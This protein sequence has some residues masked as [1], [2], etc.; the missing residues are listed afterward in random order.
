MLA[1]LLLIFAPA[2]YTPRVAVEAAYVLNTSKFPDPKPECC[3]LCKCGIITHG[4][5]HKTMC[6]CP[7]DCKCKTQC[8]PPR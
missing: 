6:A 4:D 2:D 7:S 8:K 5:G 3:G 1:E